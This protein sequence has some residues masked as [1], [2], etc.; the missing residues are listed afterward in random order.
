MGKMSGEAIATAGH[1]WDFMPQVMPTR[2]DLMTSRRGKNVLP[3]ASTTPY[4]GMRALLLRTG[5]L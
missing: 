3:G 5:T 1:P 2:G 4:Y